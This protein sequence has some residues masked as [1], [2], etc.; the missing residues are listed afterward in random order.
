VDCKEK[1]KK[2]V[3]NYFGRG[4]NRLISMYVFSVKNKVGNTSKIGGNMG[5]G[6]VVKRC[7]R[8]GRCGKLFLVFVKMRFKVWQSVVDRGIFWEC[9]IIIPQSGFVNSKKYPYIARRVFEKWVFFWGV[10][11]CFWV[12]CHRFW[13]FAIVFLGVWQ[14]GWAILTFILHGWFTITI[15]TIPI[16]IKELYNRYIL[17]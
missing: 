8:C 12:F 16:Y 11:G 3:D 7:G 13:L 14:S 15:P 10:F 9:F 2:V 6:S 1:I 5:I 4:V 17:V